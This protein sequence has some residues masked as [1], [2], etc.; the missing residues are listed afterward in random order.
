[1]KSI[2][3]LVLNNFTADSRVTKEAE[4]LVKLGYAVAVFA[5]HETGLEKRERRGERLLVERIAIRTKEW[6]KQAVVQLV[7]WLEWA[8]RALSRTRKFDIVHCNDLNTLP[9][10]VLAKWLT[11]NRIK[12]VYDSHEYAINDVPNES[13]ISTALKYALE[14][15]F[16]GF[17][18]RV[19]TV[20][21]SI[22]L[23]YARL[24]RIDKPPVVLNAPRF[25]MT[26]P[27]DKFRQRFDLPPDTVVFLYQGGLSPGR[28]IEVILSAFAAFDDGSR[29]IVFMGNG[30]L[31][32]QVKKVADSKSN[33]FYLPA[34]SQTEL[35]DYTS[36]ADAGILF[37]QN[38]CRNHD[39]CSPNKMFEYLMAE[40]PVLVSNLREMRQLVERHGIGIV[41]SND[42]PDGLAEAIDR[43]GQLDR[44]EVRSNIRKFKRKFN[45][46]Q[47]EEVLARI[48]DAL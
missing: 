24:Y 18:D 28:G 39:L 34:V 21:E 26:A 35:L 11:G 32:A 29:V 42:Q 15:T 43:F 10:G 5:I 14:Y 3:C 38:N 40:I 16:I 25:A 47:Q 33:V 6:P 37:Y 13:R 31:A 1:M 4:S 44:E 27:N 8:F 46:E 19:I 7:K 9:V 2:A 41:A 17:A 48:Y 12:L 45:W 22:A 23:E 30:P 36:S 20:S